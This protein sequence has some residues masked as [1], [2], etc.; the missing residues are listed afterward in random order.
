MPRLA[1]VGHGKMGRA[2]EQLAAEHGWTIAAVI[3]AAANPN[4]AAITAG[5]LGGADVAVEFTTSA[6]APANIRACVHAGCPVVSGTTG[7][8]AQ[9]AGVEEDVLA[10]DG[11]M[12]W[13]PNFSI[14]VNVFWQVAELAARLAGRTTTFDAHIIETHHATKR[15]A[16]SGTALALQRLATTAFGSDIPVSSVR[17]GSVPGTHELVLDG[18]FEQI[19]VVH[20]ARDRRAFAEG[21][22]LAARWLVGR[23]GVY[24]MRDFLM[25]EVP[26][27]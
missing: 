1:I 10:G 9:R 5:S 14:G 16:P 26:P 17:V 8:D 15:D 25:A 27:A 7:W 13:S 6:A 3:D 22:L 18:A 23:R 24:T 20:E 11:A 4:A 21:A 2:V 12:L 19:R